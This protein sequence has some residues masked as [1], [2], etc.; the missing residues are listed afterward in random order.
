MRAPRANL[1]RDAWAGELDA[2]RVDEHVRVAGWVNRRTAWADY[3]SYGGT[4]DIA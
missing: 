1:Y 4:A 2:A 3:P